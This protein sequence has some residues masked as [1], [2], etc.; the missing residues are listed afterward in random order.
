M[1][2]L[3]VNHVTEGVDFYE[4]TEDRLSVG[5]TRSQIEGTSDFAHGSWF[6]THISGGLNYQVPTPSSVEL[7]LFLDGVRVGRASSV[8]LDLSCPLP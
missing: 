2:T 6:W 5:W 7:L 4:K 1:T 3:Q 8:P